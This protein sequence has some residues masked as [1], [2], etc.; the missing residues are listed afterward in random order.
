MYVRLQKEL[1]ICSEEEIKMTVSRFVQNPLISVDQIIPSRDDFEVIG[2]FNAGVAEFNDETILLLRVAERPINKDSTKYLSPVFDT[3]SCKVEVKE[4]NKNDPDIDF[5]DSRV[6]KTSKNLYLTSMSHLRLAKSKNG[7][8]FEIEDTPALFPQNEYEAFGIED[9]RITFIDDTYYINYSCG[10]VLGV[11]TLLA[12]TKDFK[13]F[14]RHGVIFCPDN[15]DVAIFPEKINGKYYALHRPSC[16]HFAKPEMWI[17]ESDNLIHWG[18]HRYLMGVKENDWE[19]T[20]IGA[21][22]VPLKTKDGWLCIYHG[23][24]YENSYSQ[25]VVLLDLDEP[26]KILKRSEE[27]FMKPEEDYEMEGF[28]NSVIF[29][30]GAIIK[31]NIVKMYY[32]GADTC[33]ACAEINADYLIKT[34]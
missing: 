22:A 24:D 20:R 19:S 12:S 9:P 31:D 3:E 18:N 27:P 23:A 14:E 2:V 5:S 33:V 8:D 6:I 34:L 32:G 25:G 4:F 11:T 1:Q 29:S 26:W 17:A 30:C 21:S 10:S 13:T 28:F 7:I 16:S 15:K